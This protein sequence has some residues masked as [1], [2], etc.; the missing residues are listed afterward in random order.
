[1][2]IPTR[3]VSTSLQVDLDHPLSE[4]IIV[5]HGDGDKVGSRRAGDVVESL[6]A[7][8]NTNTHS[9]H[10]EYEG[11]FEVLVVRVSDS[12]G[13]SPTYSSKELSKHIF[14]DDLTMVNILHRQYCQ[15]CIPFTCFLKK[16][17]ALIHSTHPLPAS[18]VRL[19]SQDEPVSCLLQRQTPICP[20]RWQ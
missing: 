5:S 1:M 4:M 3:L 16:S 15:R 14:T 17:N 13:H 19:R 2:D 9:L 11:R 6:S 20:S 18:Y 10:T 12:N 8:N 7:A